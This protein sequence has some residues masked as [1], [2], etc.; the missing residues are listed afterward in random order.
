[1]ITKNSLWYLH[2]FLSFEVYPTRNSQ[3]VVVVIKL[4]SRV[5]LFCDPMDSQAPLSMGFSRQ[6][7]WSGLPFPSSGDP[8]NP[9]IKPAS[10]A[11]QADSLPL[12]QKGSP[13][14]DLPHFKV[15]WNS[16]Y[17]KVLV[18]QSCPTLWDPMDYSP[19][20]CLVHGI[21]QTRILEWV[22]IPSPGDLPNPG[23]ESRSPALQAISLSIEPPGNIISICLASNLVYI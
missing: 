7:Y 10:P 8:P 23:T 2:S 20:G 16:L 13:M 15:I 19:P 17:V 21:L 6:E 12:S 14:S 3:M 22:V 1:M 5:Q 9:G 11:L 4:L 18:P